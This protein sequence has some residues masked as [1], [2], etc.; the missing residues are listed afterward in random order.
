MRTS[1][2]T[3]LALC[4]ATAGTAALPSLV[5]L[6][7]WRAYASLSFSFSKHEYA[8]LKAAANTVAPGGTILRRAGLPPLNVPAAGD[9]G[10]VDFIQ[11]LLDG[12]MIF[13]AGAQRPPYVRLPAGVTARYFPSSGALPLW[14]VKGMGWFGDPQS[15]PTRPYPWPSELERLQGIY[16]AGVVTL[17]SR[18]PG[19]DFSGPAAV[20]SRDAILRTLQGE[21]VG[22]FNASPT[23]ADP[24]QGAEYNQPFFLTLL[25]HVAQACFGDPIYGGNKNYVYWDMINF[26]GPSYINRGGPAPGQGWT[27][28]DM[29]G[30]FDRTWHPA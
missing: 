6:G 9:G 28:K 26:S 29:Q 30:P 5:R 3:F 25:D 1:R 27:W 20:S 17:D 23:S 21:E 8:V 4:L 14:K 19:G 22:S 18:A 12:T 7:A 24:Y 15:R 10:A 11:N 13:A 16:R 2:R